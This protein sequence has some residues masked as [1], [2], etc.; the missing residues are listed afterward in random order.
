MSQLAS[1]PKLRPKIPETLETIPYDILHEICDY[2]PE[3]DFLNLIFLSKAIFSKLPDSRLNLCQRTIFYDK[4][5][6]GFLEELAASSI[7]HRRKIRHIVLDLSS[8][9]VH[10][11][12]P[13]RLDQ[14]LREYP[15]STI[16]EL[17]Q[18]CHN[19]LRIGPDIGP[20][21]ASYGGSKKKIPIDRDRPTSS[22]PQSSQ[23]RTALKPFLPSKAEG[24]DV[25]D[26][27]DVQDN[28]GVEE[29]QNIHQLC[30]QL[31]S[32]FNSI[33]DRQTPPP[34]PAT[35]FDLS[36]YDNFFLALTETFKTLPNLRI[37]EIRLKPRTQERGDRAT[38]SAP[39]RR[40]NPRLEKLL[41]NNP[42]LEKL[43]WQ[44]WFEPIEKKHEMLFSWCFKELLLCSVNAGCSISEI[45]AK[46]LNTNLGA[47]GISVAEKFNLPPS[48]TFVGLTRL[49]MPIAMHD[50]SRSMPYGYFRNPEPIIEPIFGYYTPYTPPE[51]VLD[52]GRTQ[53]VPANYPPTPTNHPPTP[54][55]LPSREFLAFL[56]NVEHLALQRPVVACWQRYWDR[57]PGFFFDSDRE[58]ILPRLRRLEITRAALDSGSLLDFLKLNNKTLRELVCT[59]PFSHH[60]TRGDIATFLETLK[61]SLNLEICK[62]ELLTGNCGFEERCYLCFDIEGSL[63]GAAGCKYRIGM[64]CESGEK[65]SIEDPWEALSQEPRVLHTSW[66]KIKSWEKLIA[67][68]QDIDGP[69]SCKTHWISG[70]SILHKLIAVGLG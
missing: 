48:N 28:S 41:T 54:R 30:L 8:P 2:L 61:T 9:Y 7:Q 66:A 70:G 64:K 21:N 47:D 55:D 19:Y 20:N 49:E 37:L 18:F 44:D 13:L 59:S 43:P 24:S 25:Q 32:I 40:Y 16:A 29:D 69:Q 3:S 23:I 68:I 46:I 31:L 22:S 53:L 60:M 35:K 33:S 57:G 63:G 5:E 56:Q 45:R 51:P 4:K 6:I 34:R 11:V 12:D 62:L 14:I 50:H 39:W 42:E 15:N 65:M 58:V 1:P 27:S 10:F 52:F 38:I 67:K 26:D 17:S 36:F